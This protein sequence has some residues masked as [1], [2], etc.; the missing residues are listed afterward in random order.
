MAHRRF[1]KGMCISGA[2]SGTGAGAR[3]LSRQMA[4]LCAFKTTR[5]KRADRLFRS[6]SVASGNVN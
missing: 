4:R 5:K 1:Q 6:C 3:M 2:K